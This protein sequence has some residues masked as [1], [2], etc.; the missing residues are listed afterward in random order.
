[1]NFAKF[2]EREMVFFNG[3]M[4][5][6][7][8][9]EKTIFD[10]FMDE[11]IQLF[12]KEK[13]LYYVRGNHETRGPF[14]TYFQDYFNPRENHIYGTL[15]DG[16]IFF[17]LLD[18]GEDKPDSDLE[19][20]GITD[21]DNYRTEQMEWL[22]QVVASDA[23]KQAKFKVVIAHIPPVPIEG[24]WHGAREVMEKFI[25]ILNKADIDI[26]FCGHLHQHVYAEPSNKIQFPILVNSNN[27]CVLAETRGNQLNVKVIG[28]DGK[29]TFDKNY[30]AK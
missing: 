20:S 23:F 2:K 10:G 15:Q 12:A 27:S 24:A 18:T 30:P 8:T 29:T 22:K 17:I 7:F 16:P 4:V 9:D 6:Q 26:M 5:S 14:A 19:Y 1:M 25:P 28:L 13:P 21:Y 11:S 3:D